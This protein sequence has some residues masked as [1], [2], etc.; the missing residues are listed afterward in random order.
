[1]VDAIEFGAFI[2]SRREELGLSIHEL[3]G[4]SGISVS[5][6]SRVERGLRDIPN[7][8]YLRKLA[9]GLE[10]DY[11]RLM[12]AAGFLDRAQ[13]DTGKLATRD[14]KKMLA[15]QEVMFDGVPLTEED[16]AMVQGVLT[17]LFLEAKQ[18][19]KRKPGPRKMDE[20]P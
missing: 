3:S 10:T 19:N 14:L 8:A 20:S 12:Q 17:K 5:Y 18:M 16:R 1:M 4:A 7:P 9:I 13:E 15:Q 2:K 11:E 6:L